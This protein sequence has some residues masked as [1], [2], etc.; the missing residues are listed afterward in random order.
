[1]EETLDTLE[2]PLADTDRRRVLA[3]ARDLVA[4]ERARAVALCRGR[5]VLWESTDLARSPAAVAREE[6]RAR[7]NEATYLADLIAA[8]R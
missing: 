2:L 3:W 5:A 1:M 4:V 8:A 6:A 7:A